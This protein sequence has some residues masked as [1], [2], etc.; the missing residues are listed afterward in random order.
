MRRRTHGH[1]PQNAGPPVVRLFCTRG[2]RDAGLGDPSVLVPAA[3]VAETLGTF[4]D[5]RWKA[6]RRHR[7]GRALSDFVIVAATDPERWQ[8]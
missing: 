3:A 6:T 8:D 5:L 1:A 4:L 7:R 2:G